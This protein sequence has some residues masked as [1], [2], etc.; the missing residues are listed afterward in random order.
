MKKN[1][2][3]AGIKAG[4]Q[5]KGLRIAP[6]TAAAL[7]A[8]YNAPAVSTGRL[9]LCLASPDGS[10]EM[11]PVFIVNGKRG[12]K[13]PYSLTEK[14]PGK[15]EVLKDNEKYAD[16]IPLPRP[17]FYDL[18]TSGGSPMSKVAVIVGPGH[19]RSVVSQSC[20]YQQT[21][22]ACKFCAVQYWW[23]AMP[24]KQ[25]EQVAETAIAGYREGAVKHISLTTATSDTPDKGLA[26][27]VKTAQLI[28]AQ[29]DVPIMLEFEPV[30]DHA[31][32]RSLL[33]EAKKAGV[34]TVSIN[35]EVFDEKRREEIMPAKGRIP[36]SEYIENWKIC[37]EI[38]GNNEVSTTVVVGIGEGDASIIKGVEMAAGNGVMTFLVP[39]SPAAGAAYEDFIPPSADR[40][41]NLYE[42]AAAIHK[43]Y[44]LDMCACTAGCVRGG[45]F[46]AIKDVTRF[47]A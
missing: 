12:G 23:N 47:G 35:I 40:M 36:V 18:K 20:Y 7:E 26:S 29:A 31:L 33:S 45:G 27:L 2:S 9:V 11:L 46:S 32:L 5:E 43:K 19:L 30:T 17:K 3:V 13:S 34:T 16:V 41:L 37:R 14:E 4:L 21:G 22:Q 24:T 42:K 39:H 38:F 6:E 44:G 28:H 8:G 10:G 1:D 15:F 25:P